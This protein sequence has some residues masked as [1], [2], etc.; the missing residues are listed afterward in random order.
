MNLTKKVI[1]LGIF[2][3]ISSVVVTQNYITVDHNGTPSLF[4]DMQS[5]I[6]SAQSGDYIYIPGGSFGLSSPLIIDKE[7]HIFG[8]GH[9]PDSSSTTNYTIITGED[10]LITGDADNASISG[11]RIEKNLKIGYSGTG[12]QSTDNIEVYRCRVEGSTSLSEYSDNIYIYENV[13]EGNVNGHINGNGVIFS[14]NIFEE[15]IFEFDNTIFINNIF[16]FAHDDCTASASSSCNAVFGNLNTELI[17]NCLFE[18]NIIY[19]RYPLRCRHTGGYCYYVQNCIFNNNLFIDNQSFPYVTNVGT[20]NIVNQL[21]SSIFVN[22]SGS[23][24][25]YSHDYHLQSTCPGKNAGTDGTDIGIYGTA[26]PY[27]DGAVPANPHIRSKAITVQNNVI[28]VNV[29]VAAQ[30]R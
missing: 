25:S 19:D 20:N 11:I 21:K 14:K 17:T 4:S 13:F 16:L 22:Q 3:F 7:V 29:E 2:L 8:A 1:S 9:Y 18:N 5:A 10:V 23:S 26:E 12:W 24:F 15:Y 28:Q 6:N 30:E 27:K